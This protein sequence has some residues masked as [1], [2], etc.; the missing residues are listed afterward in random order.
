MDWKIIKD[1]YRC[2]LVNKYEIK[3][4]GE[5]KFRIIKYSPYKQ[6][7][8]WETKCLPDY[9]IYMWDGPYELESD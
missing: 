9:G 3:Y 8:Y 1:I 7:E 5:D 6:K 4:L 2:V